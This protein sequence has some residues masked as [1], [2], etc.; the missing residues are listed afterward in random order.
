M[1]ADFG[2]IFVVGAYPQSN[3]NALQVTFKRNLAQGLRFNANYTWSHAIDDVV[4]FFKDYQDE[5]NARAERASSDQDVRH[6]FTFDAG[7]DLPLP[8]IGLT[9]AAALD[10][11]R[12]AAQH[13]HADQKRPSGKRDQ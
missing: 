11:G 8:S 6:N 5:N 9:A 2:D 7:Y 13:D 10:G 12:L 4:G 3:Y 1:S